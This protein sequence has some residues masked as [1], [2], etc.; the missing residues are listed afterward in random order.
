MGN[1]SPSRLNDKKTQRDDKSDK[2]SMLSS[3]K[4]TEDYASV[5]TLT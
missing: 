3:V 1:G 5:D 2:S 4:M